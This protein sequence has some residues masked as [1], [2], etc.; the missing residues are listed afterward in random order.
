[1]DTMFIEHETELLDLQKQ[2]ARPH[3]S[4]FYEDFIELDSVVTSPITGDILELEPTYRKIPSIPV[5]HIEQL[6]KAQVFHPVSGDFL[7]LS[8]AEDM[9]EGRLWW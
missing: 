6:K 9:I 1:M 2:F 8:G 3:F 7:K 5:T 4:R